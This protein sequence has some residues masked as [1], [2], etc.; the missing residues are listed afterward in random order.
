MDVRGRA[1]LAEK[2]NHPSFKK[3]AGTP[4][5][6]GEKFVKEAVDAGIAV[7]YPNRAAADIAMEL[8]VAVFSRSVR[9]APVLWD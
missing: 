8:R 9:W 2:G 7:L 1:A 4:D 3:R 6:P 5:A